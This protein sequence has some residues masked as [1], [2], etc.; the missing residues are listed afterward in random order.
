[1]L[2]EYSIKCIVCD[3]LVTHTAMWRKFCRGGDC[4]K[5]FMRLR[6]FW[7]NE[8]KSLMTE[9]EL[10]LFKKL[11]ENGE[12]EQSALRKKNSTR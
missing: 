10:I 8:N 6:R 2:P 9:E 12:F 7:I 1:M 4:R 5:Q 3:S 11:E